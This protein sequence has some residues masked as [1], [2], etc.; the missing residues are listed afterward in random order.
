M[1]KSVKIDQLTHNLTN[2]SQD[3]AIKIFLSMSINVSKVRN[4]I[5]T[6]KQ[7]DTKQYL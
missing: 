3:L 7:K 6:V 2:K 4:N 5:R 1:N